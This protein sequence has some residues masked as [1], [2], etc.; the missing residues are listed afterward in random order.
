MIHKLAIQKTTRRTVP[1]SA[2]PGRTD[3]RAL[4]QDIKTRIR[5]AQLKASLS[6]NR[7]L[8]ELYWDI[9]MLI[10]RRQRAQGWGKSVVEKLAVDIQKDFPGIEGF[11]PRNIWRMRAF[12]LAWTHSA[13]ESSDDRRDRKKLPRPVADLKSRFPPRP[14]AEIPWGH[15]IILLEKLKDCVQRLWYAQQT[16]TNGW[17]KPMLENWIESDLYSR[18]GKAVTNFRKAL[19]APQ[20]D[21]ANE[22]IRDPYNF[23]F[24]TLRSDAAEKEPEEGLLAHIRK[25]LIELGAGFAFVGQQV[26]L[27]VDDLLRH[28]ADEPSIGLILC[29]TRN[30]FVAE[31]A[32][33]N[34]ATP[35]GV[36]RYTTKLVESLPVEFKGA[37]PTT[38]QIEAELAPKKT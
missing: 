4:L 6:V 31:Y 9:G 12:F 24:L 11:S 2:E 18:Q 8:I 32:L 34:V 22:V 23:G 5:A 25:F 17:S 37:L 38:Q 30:K 1:Q 27:A 35:I 20:S 13:P 28:P 3:Y 21:L 36:A 19:P 15:N 10:V 26:P 33:R 16:I 7:E 14:V 29:K